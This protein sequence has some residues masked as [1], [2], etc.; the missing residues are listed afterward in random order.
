MA[1]VRVRP[2]AQALCGAWLIASA[3]LAEPAAPPVAQAQAQAQAQDATTVGQVV[4]QG[5]SPQAKKAFEKAVGQFL[6]DM[7]RPGPFGQIG[8]WAEPVCPITTGLTPA[9]DGFV[10]TRI[11]EVAARVGAPGPGDCRRGGNVMVIFTTQPD[12]LM[13][14]IRKH[15]EGLLGYHYVGETKALAA[16]E[17]PMKSW[18]VT[19]TSVEGG[20]F[21]M[22]DQAYAPGPPQ[23]GSHIQ[24]PLQSRFAFVLVVVD[25]KLMEGQEI[26]PVADRIA[27]LV[28]SRPAPHDGC[29]SL[30]SVMDFLD[31]KCHGGGR[32]E[33]LTG[34]DEAYLKA[35]Y[36]YKG[37]EI[38]YFERKS[39]AKEIMKQSSP[40][41][42]DPAGK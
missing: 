34:Y 39:M 20:D 2:L 1:P 21:V 19:T 14:Y 6:H 11:E 16:F 22:L 23:G 5:R 32:Q 15:R 29:S 25:A 37:S 10:N 31:P 4:V 24:L 33:G 36:A 17:P 27:M 12:E 26:G 40:P 9:M 28:L 30:A 41:P 35:L 3:A 8:R 7:G 42:P 13:A 18:Y 38:R